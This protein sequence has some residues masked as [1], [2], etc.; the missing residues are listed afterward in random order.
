MPRHKITS[1][2][3]DRIVIKLPKSL[4]AFFRKAFRHGRRSEFVANCI[5]RYQREQEIA[6]MEDDLREVRDTRIF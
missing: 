3:I 4:A 5:R 2:P 6:A 1:E